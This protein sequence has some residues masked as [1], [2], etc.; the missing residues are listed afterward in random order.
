[1][2]TLQ[3]SETNFVEVPVSRLSQEALHGIVDEFV[4]REG[5]DYGGPVRTMEE[6]RESI[7]LQLKKG[8]I[9]IVFDPESESC[10]IITKEQLAG[11]R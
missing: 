5:T 6:K 7:L 3:D 2:G 10:N 4:S 9:V 1:M 11:L 8:Q